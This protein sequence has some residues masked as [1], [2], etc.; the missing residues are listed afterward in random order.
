MI[1][2]VRPFLQPII[3][4]DHGSDPLAP[5]T[6]PTNY[7]QWRNFQLPARCRRWFCFGSMLLDK[8]SVKRQ[9]LSHLLAFV[10]KQGTSKTNI[11]P[12][13]SMR[14]FSFLCFNGLKFMLQH[15]CC[16][17]CCVR[18]VGLDDHVAFCVVLLWTLSCSIKEE[19]LVRGVET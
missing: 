16:Q 6:I 2:R 13:W 9:D 12:N 3:I 14:V 10:A 5:T 18:D 7:Q 19:T 4:I 8:L 11:E 17:G 15:V 1:A